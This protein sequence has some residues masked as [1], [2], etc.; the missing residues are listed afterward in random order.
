MEGRPIKTNSS[1]K[2][3]AS[4]SVARLAGKFNDQSA[5]AAHKEVAPPKPFRKKPPCTLPLP[6]IKTES[7]HNGEEKPAGNAPHAPKNKVKNSPIIEKLQGNLMFP[8]LPGRSPKS[9]G[10]KGMPSPFHSP[11]STPN[12]P[13]RHSRSSD[14]DTVPVSFENP[15]EEAPLRGLIKRTKGSLNRRPPSRKFRKSQSDMEDL[16]LGAVSGV[17][18]QN[19]SKSEECDEVFEARKA[20]TPEPSHHAGSSEVGHTS[21]DKLTD[22]NPEVKENAAG[23]GADELQACKDVPE[24]QVG[25]QG[26]DQEA[27]RDTK[28]AALA[29]KDED[30]QETAESHT[31]CQVPSCEPESTTTATELEKEQSNPSEDKTDASAGDEG[32]GGC[33]V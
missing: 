12:S 24:E 27:E 16:D 19:G 28:N 32:S 10:F 29:A 4:S 22:S 21:D 2:Q 23:N 15:P 20:K 17:L 30:K 26:L 3:A 1:V 14:S 7:G 33:D 9:P 6:V 11:P 18:K 5:T 8:P 25:T 31:E 13:N